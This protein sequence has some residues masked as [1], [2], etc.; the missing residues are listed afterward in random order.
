MQQRAHPENSSEPVS[1]SEINTRQDDILYGSFRMLYKVSYGKLKT[2]ILNE[3][4][5]QRML[6]IPLGGA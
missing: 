5:E 2:R 1:V 3:G 4:V 6:M